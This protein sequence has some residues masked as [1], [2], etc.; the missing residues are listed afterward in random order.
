MVD[1]TD[2]LGQIT[3]GAD[4]INRL[5]TSIGN[6]SSVIDKF[7]RSITGGSSSIEKFN[8]L[9]SEAKDKTDRT[10]ESVKKS[11]EGFKVFDASLAKATKT[12]FGAI[13]ANKGLA[14]IGVDTLLTFQMLSEG[15]L[16]AGIALTEYSK[17][18]Q[19]ANTA[20]LKFANSIGKIMALQG[21]FGAKQAKM[22]E[23]FIKSV[24]EVKSFEN[25]IMSAAQTGGNFFNVYDQGTEGMVGQNENAMNK[26]ARESAETGNMLGIHFSD[27]H[28]LIMDVMGKLPGEF[29]KI[30]KD[31]AIDGNTYAMSTAEII[32]RVTRGIGISTEEGLGIASDMIYKFGEDAIESAERMSVMSQASK[33]LG[34]RF[35]DLSGLAGSLDDTFDMWGNQLESV[36]PV[37]NDVSKAL[38]GTNV[39]IKGQ[40]TL[41]KNLMSSVE[42]I[43]L[44]MKSFIGVMSGMR[45]PGGAIGV[46]LN[47]ERMLQEGRSGEVVNMIQESMQRLTGREAISLNEATED[48]R[49]QR[50][51][52][53]QRKMLQSMTG[54]SN[55]GQLNR[56][57]E[58][59]SKTEVGTSGM[60]NASTALEEAL[61]NS[62]DIVSKQTDVMATVSENLK[63]LESTLHATNNLY[64]T[65]IDK[66]SAQGTK[67]VGLL[68][69][70]PVEQA[71]AR[72]EDQRE[73]IG[74]AQESLVGEAVQNLSNQIAVGLVESFTKSSAQQFELFGAT[75]KGAGM[76]LAEELQNTATPALQTFGATLETQIDK[77]SDMS[78]NI[79]GAI[80]EGI[81]K[82]LNSG[83]FSGVESVVIN[84]KARTSKEKIE[85]EPIAMK[86]DL[87][88][89]DENGNSMAEES[90]DLIS[91]V[92]NIVS[93]RG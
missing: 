9:S 77:L 88:I 20:N 60:M 61:G 50:A 92:L 17:H 8:L 87:T 89:K 36:I 5:E 64:Q 45:G 66:V 25:A 7:T 81:D 27:A 54:I 35:S 48:P 74:F 79:I 38:E 37:L 62:E 4:I 75:I 24:N 57:L 72:R 22:Y 78:G 34:M 13:D 44:P 59:M 84:D 32:G 90:Y 93:R 21:E 49:A 23:N 42:S 30:Y 33:E 55:T 40:L 29:G 73:K 82:S 51:F 19:E 53:V 10:T 69:M 11:S 2:A 3:G 12:I 39:G 31:I 46:G 6:L 16:D 56:L 58:V 14:R 91:H 71:M 63:S 15:T 86:L 85:F 26:I 65:Y 76:D 1:I 80:T 28:K 18:S 47:I 52:L 83:A 43:Q 67:G 70:A 68:E 41:V